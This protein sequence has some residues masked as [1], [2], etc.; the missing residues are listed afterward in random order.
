MTGLLTR[1]TDQTA[2]PV[3]YRDIEQDAGPV[4]NA[5]CGLARS[6]GDEITGGDASRFRELQHMQRG[7]GVAGGIR[8]DRRARQPRAGGSQA[9]R[10]RRAPSANANRADPAPT[11]SSCRSRPRW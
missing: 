9:R 7:I 1:A 6:G 2:L 4:N 3:E 10:N 8:R 5:A 11:S